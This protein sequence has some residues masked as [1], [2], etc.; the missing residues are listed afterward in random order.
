MSQH[1]QRHLVVCKTKEIYDI[2]RDILSGF[3]GPKIEMNNYDGTSDFIIE[4]TT[5]YAEFLKIHHL[6]VISDAKFASV[7]TYF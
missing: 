3:D 7:N 6:S 2:T 4:C 1:N 5:E